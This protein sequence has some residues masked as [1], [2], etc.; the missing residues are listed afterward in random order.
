MSN[1]FK[2]YISTRFP[3]KVRSPAEA[4][5]KGAGAFTDAHETRLIQHFEGRVAFDGSAPVLPYGLVILAFTNRSGSNMLADYL[6]QTRKVTGLGEYLNHVT[7]I[8]QTTEKKIDSFPDYV[9]HL[10]GSLT[11]DN[12][13]FGVKASAE[14]L[15]FLKRW[16]ITD[17]FQKVSVVHVHRDD[18]LAQAV[19]LWIAVQTGQWTSL[20]KRHSDDVSVDLDA[21]T[22]ITR[23]IT[24]ED[25]LIR[26]FCGFEGL[27]YVS[28]SYEEVI[29]DVSAAVKRVGASVGF[30]ASKVKF[31][32]PRIGKQASDLNEQI[33]TQLRQHLRQWPDGDAG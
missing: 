17:M 5:A 6:R 1:R 13:Q 7:T 19:S 27:N 32:A 15:R 21:I 3:G 33:L 23:D 28:L 12:Q 10:A 20:Q 31:K 14:Q 24:T 4:T 8:K 30:D 26:Q 22:A 25:G 9:A 16:R 29:A 11:R 2:N 18:L